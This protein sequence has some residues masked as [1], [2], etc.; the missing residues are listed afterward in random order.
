MARPPELAGGFAEMPHVTAIGATALV[1]AAGPVTIPLVAGWNLVSLPQVPDNPDPAAVLASIAGSYEE[2]QAFDG[3]SASPT[4]IFDPTASSGNTLTAIDQRI[5][6]WIKMTSPGALSVSG[7]AP[8]STSLHLCAGLN[9]VGYPLAAEL[10]VTTV[11]API[12][13]KFSRVY[14]FN[15]SKPADP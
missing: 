5:G 9:L 4:R 11:L 3:C 14:G 2:A 6:A 1:A 10:P 15:A 13:G 7:T 8:S 12:A